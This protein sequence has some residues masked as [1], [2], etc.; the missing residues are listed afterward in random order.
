MLALI[1]P[2][3]LS[4]RTVSA[5]LFSCPPYHEVPSMSRVLRSSLTTLLMLAGSLSFTS[6][7]LAQQ[8]PPGEDAMHAG[9]DEHVTRTV[10]VHAM[11]A[12][13]ALENPLYRGDMFAL[14][15][16]VYRAITQYQL[17]LMAQPPQDE[18]DAVRLKIAWLYMQADKLPAA[19]D[20]LKQVIIARPAYDRLAIWARLYYGDVAR[21]AEQGNVAVNTYES[22]LKECD[23]LIEEAT[24]NKAG[25][26]G[27]GPG[28]CQY[29]EGYARLGLASHFANVHDF[30][31][32]VQ[33]LEGIPEGSP[34]KPKTT[35]IANY[36]EGLKLPRKRPALAGALSIIPGLGHLYIEEY[37][38]ALVAAVWNGAFIWAFVD[39]VRSKKYGQATLIGVVEFVWYSG[40]IFGAVAGAHRF[41][42]DARRIVEEGII[43]DI[44]KIDD[45][46]PWI[47]RF[48]T[49][50]P[51]FDLSYTWEF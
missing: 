48:P 47:S 6:T 17:H 15:G 11:P 18:A 43:A 42:R 31:R 5:A 19:A 8:A 24:Q 10:V 26:A 44:Q 28:D 49:P 20:M 40:T 32:T 3:A 2:L 39:S 14:E 1:G 23:A 35:E 21:M 13:D 27:I 9:H 7:G 22:L 46:K 16:D 30:T 50:E 33:E 51:T 12:R 38:S 4:I 25:E 45:P 36:V 34:L 37:G 41:N 29:I